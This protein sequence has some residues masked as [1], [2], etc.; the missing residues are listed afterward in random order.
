MPTKE[1]KQKQLKR[2]AESPNQ[3]KLPFA[4]KARLYDSTASSQ[5]ESTSPDQRHTL[6]VVDETSK[7]NKKLAVENVI[8]R[9]VEAVQAGRQPRKVKQGGL[10]LDV[11][12]IIALKSTYCFFLAV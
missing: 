6:V 1:R 2:E 7:P 8:N 4:E 10:C 9:G 12:D 5:T 11:A 3:R